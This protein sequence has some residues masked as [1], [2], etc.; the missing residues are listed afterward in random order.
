M[1][2][3]ASSGKTVRIVYWIATVQVALVMFMG[4]LLDAIR[5]ESALEVFHHLGYPNYFATVLGVA[6]VLGVVAIL[7]PVPRALRVF[8]YAGFTFDV[9]AA[10]ISI[11]AV[12]DPWY[13][14]AIPTYAL[15]MVLT[16]Y[17]TWSARNGAAPTA[18]AA[19]LSPNS[20]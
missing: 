1:T 6:K 14:V 8:A 10:I 2:A 20:A 19:G 5:T 17:S 7:A 4:G 13:H 3:G 18:L 16:S 11:L 12:G 15:A 9:T